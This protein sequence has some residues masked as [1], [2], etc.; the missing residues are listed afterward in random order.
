MSMSSASWISLVPETIRRS[1]RPAGLF[2]R[3]DDRHAQ[4]KQEEQCRF[5]GGPGRRDR[6]AAFETLR[7][8][9]KWETS[10]W[11]A[12]AC[13]PYVREES[14]STR[15]LDESLAW[16]EDAFKAFVKMLLARWTTS[17]TWCM[18]IAAMPPPSAPSPSASSAPTPHRPNRLPPLRPHRRRN[19]H[20]RVVPV[21][22]PLMSCRAAPT[23]HDRSTHHNYCRRSVWKTTILKPRRL[24]SR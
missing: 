15:T 10:L 7:H 21:R 24:Y 1:A 11:K 14:R 17:A 16:S 12:K 13:R 5:L 8:K 2:G 22:T 19:R 6:P 18:S 3:R 9:G 20:R 23:Q 4:E